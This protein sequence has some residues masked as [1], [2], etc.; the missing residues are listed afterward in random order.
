MYQRIGEAAYKKNLD[1]TIALMEHLKHPEKKIKSI[2][3]AGT[4]GKGS[5]AHNLA[6]IYQE[7]G[8]KTGLFT[9]PHFKDF[10]ERIRLNGER[11]PQRY[12]LE[13]VKKN[14]LFLDE[15]R[16]SFFEMTAAMAFWYFAKRQVDIAIIEVGMGGRLD[17]TN[18]IT[19][20]LSIITNIS[21]DHT[22]F[23]GNTIEDIAREKAGIIKEGVP[24]IIGETQP[25]TAE[26]FLQIAKERRAPIIFADQIFQMRKEKTLLEKDGFWMTFSTKTND[27]IV[28]RYVTPLTGMYQ[29]KNFRT[30]LTACQHI[31]KAVLSDGSIK[32]GILNC[33]SNTGFVGR[34]QVLNHHPLCIADIGHNSAGIQ[35]VAEHLAQM[36]YEKLHI[37]FGMVNDKDINYILPALPKNAIYYFCKANIPRALDPQEIKTKAQEF[38]LNGKVYPT[39]KRAYNSAKR[40]AKRND[41]VFVGGST[42]VVAEAIY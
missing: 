6:S 17:S 9:S 8:F 15:L 19:P 1:N 40:A 16:P 25:K 42:F 11:I 39:V 31:G 28:R 21:Y 2:H 27:N 34:W 14:K 12:I 22:Q 18:V 29:L 30:L 4:N 26:I 33:V 10:R 23:L 5:I 35:C 36:S 20:Q 13:F 41:L 7:A 37:V 32:D 3:I 24:I 38:G